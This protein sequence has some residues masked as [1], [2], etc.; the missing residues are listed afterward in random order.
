MSNSVKGEIGEGLSYLS[1]QLCGEDIVA[2]PASNGVGKSTF[3]FLLGSGN[4]VESKFGTSQLSGPQQDA[5]ALLGESLEVQYWDY[6]TV[7]GM[8]GSGPAASLA[9]GASK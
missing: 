8:T 2:S 1:I 5:A 6:P 7:S 3:D 9:T 4:F